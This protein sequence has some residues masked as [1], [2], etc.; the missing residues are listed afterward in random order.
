MSPL[1]DEQLHQIRDERREQ[2]MRAAMKVFAHKGSAGTKMSMIAAEARISHGLLYH[3]FKSKDALFNALV[4]EA[5]EGAALE[6]GKINHLQG[7]PL[8]KIRALTEAILDEGGSSYFMF[9]HQA[10]TSD[11][12]PE[13]AKRLLEQYPMQAFVEQLLPLFAAGQQAGEI[14]ADDPEELIASYLTVLS[15]IMI[16]S[17]H[18]GAG[19]RVPKVEMLMR[20]VTAPK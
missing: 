14:A 1:N 16:I 3:Y 12:V 10:R 8:E 15:G 2:I 5:M 9:I 18:H 20:M 4:R 6:L 17:G 7:S 11:G 13:E 19:Y